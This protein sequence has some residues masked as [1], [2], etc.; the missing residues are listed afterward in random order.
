MAIDPPFILLASAVAVAIGVA[1]S[2]RIGDDFLGA[3]RQYFA[4]TVG[5]DLKRQFIV[6]N[7]VHLF[8]ASLA[9]TAAL[10]ILCWWYL[11]PPGAICGAAIGLMLPHTLLKRLKKQRA[12]R[13]IYQLPDALHSLAASLRA[14][15]NLPRGLEQLATWQPAPLAQEF[16]VVLAEYKIGRDLGVALDRMQQR[17]ERPELE[18]MN[19]AMNISRAVGGNLAETLEALA[20]ALT[21][22]ASV[23]GKIQALTSMGRMQGWVVSVIPLF[24]G[25]A[26]YAMDPEKMMPLF[27]E[28]SGWITLG[29]VGVLMTLA[30]V[31]I[32]KIVAIDV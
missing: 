18:M 3:Y 14:G 31:T 10:T 12:E 20:L 13:F 6:A 26:I 29:V 27:T 30:V 4:E 28:V 16:G 25:G 24:I 17:I 7:W 8:F 9:M 22:K 21:E 23:E 19:S 2:F 1:A 5:P 11:G 32:R 15:V